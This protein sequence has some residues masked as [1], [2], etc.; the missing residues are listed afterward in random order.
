[1]T[2]SRPA[3][4]VRPLART[5][6]V[7]YLVIIACALFAEAFVRGRLAVPGDGAA[8]AAAVE[9]AAGLWRTALAADLVAFLA[10]VAVAVLLYV[11][12]RPFDR[13]MAAAAAALRLVGTAIYAANLLNHVAVLAAAGGAPLLGAFTGEQRGDLAAFFLELHGLGYD[14]GLVFF[15]VHCLVLMP[16]LARPGAAPRA[17]AVLMGLAGAVYVLGSLVRFLA[18]DAAGAL[19]PAYAVPLAAEL[20]LSAWLLGRGARR[21][22]PGAA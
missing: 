16:L 20:A 22:D 6:G 15:G 3:P 5:T 9:A 21:L 14:L 2:E 10:D 7:L 11:L 8:T 1:M 13:T 18:P 12:L 19:A 4:S 17:V